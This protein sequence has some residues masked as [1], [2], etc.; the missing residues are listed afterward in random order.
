MGNLFCKQTSTPATSDLSTAIDPTGTNFLLGSSNR[1]HPDVTDCKMWFPVTNKNL[2]KLEWKNR[3][4][5]QA[6][7]SLRHMSV[8]LKDILLKTWW[9]PTHKYNKN[10]PTKSVNKEQNMKLMKEHKNNK[11]Q[12][13]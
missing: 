8:H 7:M 1:L 4:L 3:L 2:E 11:K 9:K 5:K 6:C 12:K 10:T 13:K